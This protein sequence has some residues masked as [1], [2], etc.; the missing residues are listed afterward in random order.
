MVIVGEF[1]V[2]VGFEFTVIV[3]VAVVVP[4][5]PPLVVN[6]NVMLPLSDALAV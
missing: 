5:D 1:T 2:T 3:L 4:Q 6:V